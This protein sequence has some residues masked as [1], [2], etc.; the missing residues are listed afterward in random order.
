MPE[1]SAVQNGSPE[2]AASWRVDEYLD[3]D[4][5]VVEVAG[6]VTGFAVARAVAPGLEYEL[7]NI[8]IA[9][10]WRGVGLARGLLWKLLETYKG[11]W[12]LEVRESNAPAR[13]LYEAAGFRVIGRRKE[14]YRDPVEDAIEMSKHS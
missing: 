6:S 4:S 13:R 2:A 11:L 7:L 14:Y 8:A 3:H 10:D 12:F 5:W 9:P 1:V